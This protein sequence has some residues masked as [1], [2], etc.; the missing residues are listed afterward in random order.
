V[1]PPLPTAKSTQAGGV[2]GWFGAFVVRWPLVVIAF[3]VAL[4]IVL[5]LTVPSLNQ[6]AADN[7]ITVLPDEAPSIVTNQQMT[8]AFQASATTAAATA[9]SRTGDSR[10]TDVATADLGTTDPGPADPGPA[11]PGTALPVTADPGPADPAPAN[12][13]PA[14]PGS[15]DSATSDS[16]KGDA[17]TDNILLVVLTNDKGLGPADEEAYRALVKRLRQDTADVVMMQDFVSTPPVREVVTSK[18]KTAWFL[19]INLAGGLGSAEGHLAYGNV[20][21]IVEESVAGSTLT[22][23]LTGPAVTVADITDVGQRDVQMVEAATAVMVLIILLIIYRSVVTMLL[24]LI[25]ILISFVTA[26]GVISALAPL[27]LGVSGQTM[28]FMTG[29]MVGAGTDYAVFLISR[30]HDFVRRGA[31]SPQAVTKALASIGKVIAASAATVAITFLGMI[32]TKLKVFSIVGPAMAI[33][34][35][36]AFLAAVTLL[37]AMLVL[38]GPRGWVAPRRDLTSRMWRRS[39]I[40]I[41]RRPWTHFVASLTVLVIL[42]GSAGLVRY[43]YDDRKTLPGSAESTLGYDAMDRHFPL[44]ET[45]PQYLF[46]KSPHDLRT[47]QALGDLEEM[48][49][50]V[51]QSPGVAMVSGITR[52]SG[53]RLEQAKVSNQAGEVGVKLGDAAHEISD[54]WGDLDQL[55]GGAHELAGG[56]GDVRS[57]VTNAVVTVRPLVDSLSYIADQLGGEKTLKDIDDAAKLVTNMQDLGKYL[58]TN[59]ENLSNSLGWVDPVLNALNASPICSFDASCRNARSELQTWSATR[60]D[61][62]FAAITD[63]A[64]QLESTKEGQTLNSTLKDLRDGLTSATSA[65]RALGL[66]E[67]GG[68]QN[69]LATL[70]AGAD[71]L[72]DASQQLADGVQQLVDKNKE[73]GTGL[74]QASAFLLALKRNAST[75]SMA[76]F[77]IPP[78]ILSQDEFAKAADIF[79]SPDGHAVRY[80]VQSN[81]NPFSTDAMDQVNSITDTARGAQTNTALADASIS[82]TGFSATLRDTRDYYNHDVRLIM[83]VTVLVVLLILIAL[84]RAIVAPLYLI[85]SVVISYFSA[86]GIGVIMFQFILGQELHWSV[87]GLT[88]IVLVAV[89]ADYNMLLISRVRDESPHGV[90]S[91]VIRTVGSTGGVITAAGLIF[92][93]S[94][95][96]LL[97]ASISTMVQ[98]GFVLGIGLLVDTFLVRTITVPAMIALAGRANWWP[99]NDSGGEPSWWPK[100]KHHAVTDSRPLHTPVERPV[101]AET[102]DDGDPTEPIERVEPLEPD[103]IPMSKPVPR[104]AI[105]P[106]LPIP[107]LRLT[108]RLSW[109]A[110]HGRVWMMSIAGAVTL[111]V[112][113]SSAVGPQ[114]AAQKDSVQDENRPAANT[115]GTQAG[116]P[117]APPPISAPPTPQLQTAVAEPPHLPVPAAVPPQTLTLPPPGTVAVPSPNNGADAQAAQVPAAAPAPPAQGPIAAPPA[118]P[119]PPAQGPIAAP[120]AAP[121]PP[122]QEPVA[123]PPPPDPVA[124]VLSPLFG[125]LP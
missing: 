39:G 101:P 49:R 41:V 110:T 61:G 27:G 111:A 115:P 46:V 26:Q 65:M 33:A 2:F 34:I 92:A 79:V 107:A 56:L 48:A 13:A 104:A 64:R 55:A 9:D 66:N 17:G 57:S 53:E 24:P 123:P 68:L 71:T 11:D 25:T 29:I 70:Q 30:Y 99:S 108:H 69:R 58:R 113:L 109:L 82:M 45:I 73:M 50:R 91:G 121:A 80:L 122:V 44:N 124:A 7:P 88:F 74:S 78:E 21:D 83:I 85:A 59:L 6:R 10:T 19:P 112:L 90:R 23:Y 100:R 93:V 43:N 77:Y 14:N 32:F 87:P 89:G 4:P 52:P 47:P 98:S 95:F 12:P 5:T 28:V 20:A 117:G 76:G 60:G 18:D 36:V 38:A 119:A 63:L 37:P 120:P 62:S 84:L 105:R 103:T 42:A 35:A 54:R 16:V 51:S 86:L 106:K 40:R 125:G 102:G 1:S 114:H 72:A 8:E 81:L 15:A 97:F 94:M 116:V 22:A 96:G 118:A 31:D 67:P 75:P 3:W